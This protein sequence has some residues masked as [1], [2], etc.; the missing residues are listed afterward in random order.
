MRA[1]LPDAPI[2][3]TFILANQCVLFIQCLSYIPAF[4]V[5]TGGI[6]LNF[7]VSTYAI[8][9]CRLI[10]LLGHGFN[11]L[12]SMHNSFKKWYTVE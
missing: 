8:E 10:L 5:S 1:L 9:A 3:P 11:A 6:D 2:Q 12:L 7:S 4:I